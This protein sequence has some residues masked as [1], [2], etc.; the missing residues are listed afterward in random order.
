[1]AEN[2]HSLNILSSKRFQLLSKLQ[3]LHN[4]HIASVLVQE[5]SHDMKD[6]NKY[7]TLLNY[8]KIENSRVYHEILQYSKSI[9]VYSNI[10]LMMF[11]LEEYIL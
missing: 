1:M 10:S 3:G 8:L 6:N 2:L 5:L 9:K 4:N 7:I 11:L